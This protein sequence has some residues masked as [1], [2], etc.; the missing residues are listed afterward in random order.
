MHIRRFHTPYLHPDDLFISRFEE[1]QRFSV[2]EKRWQTPLMAKL[3]FRSNFHQM[4][5][6]NM[7]SSVTTNHI[8]S[9]SPILGWT[10]QDSCCLC[11]CLH[12]KDARWL[13]ADVTAFIRGLLHSGLFVGTH[14]SMSGSAS[15]KFM[16][17]HRNFLGDLNRRNLQ[18]KQIKD[19]WQ[20]LKLLLAKKWKWWKL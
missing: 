1:Y 10:H 17:V 13:V 2:K 20:W 16:V 12:P 5:T 14:W 6:L 15:G 3:F 7:F 4:S 8:K 9:S 18:Q 11:D 19:V